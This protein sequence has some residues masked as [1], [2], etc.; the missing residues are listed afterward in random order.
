MTDQPIRDQA[1]TTPARVR[2][3]QTINHTSPSQMEP[4]S[5]RLNGIG[6]YEERAQC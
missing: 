3:Y 1:T 6:G 5:T 2:A 4:V